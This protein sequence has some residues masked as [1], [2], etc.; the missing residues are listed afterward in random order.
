MGS[1]LALYTRLFA[2][3]V[4]LFRSQVSNVKQLVRLTWMV[5]SVLHARRSA[6]STLAPDLPGDLLAAA[7]D[8]RVRRWRN[9]PHVD[10]WQRYQPLLD[11]VLVGRKRSNIYRRIGG[12][13]V[14]N[15][16]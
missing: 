9:N 12:T 7:H 13:W 1:S 6:P 15:G 4:R 8:A 2:T 5:V 14:G 10:V 16:R 11:A 3:L